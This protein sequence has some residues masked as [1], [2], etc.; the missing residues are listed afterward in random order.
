MTILAKNHVFQFKLNKSK[1][2]KLISEHFY[3]S[4][5]NPKNSFKV[6]AFT[7][8]LFKLKIMFILSLKNSKS[9]NYLNNIN[10]K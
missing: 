7:F 1:F 8:L 9:Q 2:Q 6:V 3:K 10:N 5:Q 4:V